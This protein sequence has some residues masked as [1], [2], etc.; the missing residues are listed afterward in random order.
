MRDVELSM[1]HALDNKEHE[2]VVPECE[3]E[4]MKPG[5]YTN[6]TCT[7]RTRNTQGTPSYLPIVLNLKHQFAIL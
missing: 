1:H 7:D 4:D 5:P 6:P 3:Q 2:E